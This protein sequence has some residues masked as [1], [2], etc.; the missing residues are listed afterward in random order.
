MFDIS[1]IT[2]L[3]L[4]LNITASKHGSSQCSIIKADAGF[5][6]KRFIYIRQIPGF[7][8]LCFVIIIREIINYII[9]NLLQCIYISGIF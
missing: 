4:A 9:V 6:G 1:G 3:K 8:C 5:G 7:Y 2:N